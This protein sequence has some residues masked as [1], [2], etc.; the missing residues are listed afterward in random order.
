MSPRTPAW[1]P[2]LASLALSACGGGGGGGGNPPAIPA[3]LTAMVVG[4]DVVLS[5][6]ASNGATRYKVYYDLEPGVAKALYALLGE[7][8][9]PGATVSGQPSMTLYL[10]V[11]AVGPDG[12]SAL[13]AEVMAA[14]PAT[15][16]DALFADQWHLVNTGQAGGTPGEDVDVAAAWAGGFD[17]TGTR[18]AI[19]D[20]GLEIGHED[21]F[22]NCPPGESHSY[23]DGSTDPTGGAHGT[24]CAGVA[25]GVGGNDLGVRGAAFE[26]Q[27]V[28]YDLLQNLTGATEANAMTRDAAQNWVSSNSWGAPDGLGVPQASS[29]TWRNAVQSGLTNGRGG[30]GLLYVWAAGN[31]G[32]AGADPGDNSNLD[33]RANFWGVMAVG[34]VGDDGTKASYSENGA[35]LF[36][37]APSLGN[38]GH[39][40]ST[41]DRSGPAGYNDGLQLGDY[42]DANYTNTFNGT[43]AA[44][45]LVSGV[46]ALVL[47][48]NPALGW[49]DVRLILAQ[50]ARVNDPGDTDW[51]VNGAGY[52]INH[53]YGFGVPDAAAAIAAAQ[54]WTNV[55]P[56]VTHTTATETVNLPIPDDDPFGIASDVVV[57]GSGISLLEHV[58]V[59]FDAVH[60]YVGDLE[61]VLEAPSGTMSV[62]AEEHLCPQGSVP[63]SNWVFGSVRHLDEPADGTWTLHVRD[64]DALLTGTFRSWRLRFRG[65]S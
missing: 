4:T 28:G 8:P 55:G 56:L 12:E 46:V 10:A 6:T 1:I 17:G 24:S 7:V 25:A 14:V 18:I 51:D 60:P 21:L 43:S 61:V 47:Q 37:S 20:D 38:N 39:A 5:W 13:S 50:T 27:L 31:G 23:V 19:V 36:L 52:S 63:Y 9:T 53:K 32:L 40:I 34:A 26:A 35:N 3:N 45:P 54:G 2:L 41:V 65:R 64:R 22:S 48:A 16:V 42:V 44:T 29:A 57:A 33:G 49:R 59:T 58:E 15:G 11:T 30:L 62:L